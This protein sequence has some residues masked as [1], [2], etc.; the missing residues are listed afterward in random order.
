MDEFDL[1]KINNSFV[2][3]GIKIEEPWATILQLIAIIVIGMIAIKIILTIAR[4]LMERDKRVDDMLT[5]FFLH[6]I[7]VAC[8]ILLIAICLDKLGIS[9]GTIAA[10]LGAAGAALALALKDSLSNVAGGIMII[11]TQ[12]FKKGDLI[13]VGEYRGRVQ[14]IDLFLT[15]LRTLNYQTI[16]VPNGIINTSILVNETK[17]PIRRV[18]L[19]FGISYESDV[20]KAMEVMRKVCDASDLILTEPDI[21]MGVNRFEDSAVVLDLLAWCD[22]E[23]YYDARYYLT[24]HVKPAFEEAGIS[25]PYPHMDVKITRDDRSRPER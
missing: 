3:F 14:E 18:D 7:R 19:E 22:T 4:H 25:I 17:E 8:I 20:G 21:W 6:V 15:T 12:P 9:K 16:T 2:A 1:E 24:E 10:V 23:K 5:T 11:L 13:N